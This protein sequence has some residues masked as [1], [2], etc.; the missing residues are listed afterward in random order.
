MTL[1]GNL[2]S[3]WRDTVHA[4]TGK[5]GRRFALAHP[6]YCS[7]A[8]SPIHVGW[9]VVRLNQLYPHFKALLWEYLPFPAGQSAEQVC[10]YILYIHLFLLESPLLQI[11]KSKERT[12]CV[13]FSSWSGLPFPSQS[14]H[15]LSRKVKTSC[16]KRTAFW[17]GSQAE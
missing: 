3:L 6:I 1:F 9:H 15:P 8:T 5:Y 10:W 11:W 4:C 14:I 13:H 12:P 17:T 7:T 2:S 16:W